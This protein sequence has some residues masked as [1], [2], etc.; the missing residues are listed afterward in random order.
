MPSVC[1]L[2][3]VLVPRQAR[4]FYNLQDDHDEP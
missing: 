4:F 2:T 1:T 3:R